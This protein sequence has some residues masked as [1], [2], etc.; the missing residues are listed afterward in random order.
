MPGD[1]GFDDYLVGE[2]VQVYDALS[3][4]GAKVLWLNNPCAQRTAGPW[5]SDSRGG[6]LAPDRIAHAND[7]IIGEL[8]AQRPDVHV[9]DLY[10]VMCPDG[11]PMN[12]AGGVEPLRVDGIHFTPDGSLWF[13]R[14]YGD[15]LLDE[16][17]R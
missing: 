13:A 16:G 17:L 1:P 2:Y 5:P 11:K 8:S 4:G 7:A 15:Q 10:A 12:R 9:F 14:T 6:P 3:S